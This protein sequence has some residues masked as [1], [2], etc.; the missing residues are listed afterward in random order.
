MCKITKG[1]RDLAF[2]EDSQTNSSSVR[3]GQQTAEKTLPQSR[4][5]DSQTRSS[6]VKDRGQPNKVFLG[7]GHRT[8]KQA[9]PQSRTEDNQSRTEDSQTSPS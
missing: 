6:S 1:F 7:Q 3:K 5:E 9:L 2:L 8:A 4:T